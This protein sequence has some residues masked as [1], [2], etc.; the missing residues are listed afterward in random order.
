MLDENQPIRNFIFLKLN[1]TLAN[2]LDE[3]Q[4]VT[5]CYFFFGYKMIEEN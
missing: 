4:G 1:T 3:N 5:R 2:V